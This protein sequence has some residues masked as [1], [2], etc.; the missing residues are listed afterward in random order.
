[1]DRKREEEKKYVMCQ[2]PGVICHVSHVMCHVSCVTCHVSRVICHLSLM[3]TAT[4]HWCLKSVKSGF[5][6]AIVACLK[7]LD[8]LSLRIDA[9]KYTHNTL[10]DTKENV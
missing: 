3:P 2:V 7:N 5:P 8:V 6:I 1:M 10:Q 9:Q 4:A